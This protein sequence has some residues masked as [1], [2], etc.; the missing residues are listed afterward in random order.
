MAQSIQDHKRKTWGEGIWIAKHLDA[1]EANTPVKSSLFC[2]QFR[3]ICMNLPCPECSKDAL[4]YLQNNPPEKSPDVFI[5]LYE[6]HNHVNRK[7]GKAEMPFVEA[8]NLYYG[9]KIRIC[10]GGCGE[11]TQETRIKSHFN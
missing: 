2:G 6:F 7:L 10:S 5:W 1:V 3:H 9:G 8:R 11:S 4:T